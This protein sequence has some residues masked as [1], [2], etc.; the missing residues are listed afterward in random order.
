MLST[1]SWPFF[2]LAS[3]EAKGPNQSPSAFILRLVCGRVLNSGLKVAAKL[4]RMKTSYNYLRL[5]KLHC[6]EGMP[7]L[8]K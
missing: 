5:V 3:E 2:L 1:V 6:Q 8:N 4:S 7:W